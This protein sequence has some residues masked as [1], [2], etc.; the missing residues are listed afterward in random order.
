MKFV[1]SWRPRSGG[2]S[3]EVEADTKRGLA[4]FAAWK[5]PEGITYH[6][7]LASLDGGGYAVVEADDPA[8]VAE[9]PAKFGVWFDFEVV[10]VIDIGGIVPIAQE[11]IAF[12]DSLPS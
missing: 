2:S 3:S 9:G 12:R 8:L 4:A 5:P 6:Q 1:V 7:F 10:P 11:A